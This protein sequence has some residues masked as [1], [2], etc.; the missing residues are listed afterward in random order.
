[1]KEQVDSNSSKIRLLSIIMRHNSTSFFFAFADRSNKFSISR[2]NCLMETFTEKFWS[3][4]FS[5]NI[6]LSNHG[7]WNDDTARDNRPQSRF[8]DA[9]VMK[10][11]KR[12]FDDLW[13]QFYLSLPK[14]KQFMCN[15]KRWFS[16][17]HRKWV[18]L[19]PIV[20]WSTTSLLPDNEMIH[21]WTMSYDIFS[22]LILLCIARDV[23]MMIA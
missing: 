6:L 8:F 19:F 13:T 12:C 4:C 18:W 10:L 2:A 9:H 14:K 15:N 11:S 23:R 3:L 16:G 17:N 21:M 1:M 7:N 5:F 20:E 22:K